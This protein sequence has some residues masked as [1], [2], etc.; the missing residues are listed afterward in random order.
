V[1]RTVAEAFDLSA[2]DFVYVLSTFPVFARKRP[3]FFAYL[4]EQLAEWKKE[5]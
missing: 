5:A 3:V 4:Q 1:N 2:D